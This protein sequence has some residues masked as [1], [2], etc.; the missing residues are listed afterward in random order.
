MEIWFEPQRG[1]YAIHA[2]EAKITVGAIERGYK[3]SD[4]FVYDYNHAFFSP[5]ARAVNYPDAKEVAERYF[6]D[7]K[8]VKI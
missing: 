8:L 1:G 6:R 5:V 3:T 2:E 7:K 4:V